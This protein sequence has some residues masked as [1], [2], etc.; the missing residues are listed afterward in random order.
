M[1]FRFNAFSPFLIYI[2]KVA[3]KTDQF[4]IR[5]YCHIRKCSLNKTDRFAQKKARRD[6]NSKIC[7]PNNPHV[8]PYADWYETKLVAPQ[9]ETLFWRRSE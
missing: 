6:A 8:L 7:I 4:K 9:M 1:S 2:K 3:T 5:F